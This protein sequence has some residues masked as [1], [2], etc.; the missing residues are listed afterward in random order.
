MASCTVLPYL[1]MNIWLNTEKS[2]RSQQLLIYLNVSYY[3]MW[4]EKFKR[5][6]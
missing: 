2:S 3:V 1:S 6:T 5:Q 4:T